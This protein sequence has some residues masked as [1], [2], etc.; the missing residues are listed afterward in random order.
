MNELLWNTSSIKTLTIH[1]LWKFLCWQDAWSTASQRILHTDAMYFFLSLSFSLQSHH[2][3][4]HFIQVKSPS[5]ANGRIWFGS[6]SILP[7]TRRHS[8]RMQWFT[9]SQLDLPHVYSDHPES[10]TTQHSSSVLLR[11]TS[12]HW[13]MVPGLS[14]YP[15]HFPLTRRKLRRL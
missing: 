15:E 11:L 3:E 5:H 14:S 10:I 8:P 6:G 12:K 2:H 13:H 1:S 7:S 4:W 9:R